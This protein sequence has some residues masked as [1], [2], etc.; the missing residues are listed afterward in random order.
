M[1]ALFLMSTSVN[2]C[3]MIQMTTRTWAQFGIWMAIG[4][5]FSGLQRPLE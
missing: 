5:W 4:E 2:V 3:L 1:A